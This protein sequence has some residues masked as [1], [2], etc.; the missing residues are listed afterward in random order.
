M[1]LAC[2][3]SGYMYLRQFTEALL[4]PHMVADVVVNRSDKFQQFTFVVWVQNV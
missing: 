1:V 3:Q 4:C 2:F